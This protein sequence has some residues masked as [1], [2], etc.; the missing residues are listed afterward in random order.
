MYCQATLEKLK[1]S[2]CRAFGLAHD[3]DDDCGLFKHQQDSLVQLQL[4]GRNGKVL[5]AEL[6]SSD[7]GG[8]RQLSSGMRPIYLMP[9]V[10]LTQLFNGLARPS[11]LK[12]APPT[13]KQPPS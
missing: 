8:R 6:Q 1:E 9:K 4:A 10:S 2:I 7:V 12:S 11:N 13:D 5:K 3:D